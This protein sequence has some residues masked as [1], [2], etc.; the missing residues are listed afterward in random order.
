M[1]ATHSYWKAPNND[2]LVGDESEGHKIDVNKKSD[3]GTDR[4]GSNKKA[5]SALYNASAQENELNQDTE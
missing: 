5:G 2:L 1:E 4:S 3:S